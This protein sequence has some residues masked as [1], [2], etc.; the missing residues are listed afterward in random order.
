M[1]TDPDC[2]GN[3]VNRLV[4]DA[5]IDWSKEKGIYEIVLEVYDKNSPAI[6]AYEKVG[7]TKSLTEMT[8]SLPSNTL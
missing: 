7:F 6:K 3:G 1:Y 5:L 4:M 8:L 2:R